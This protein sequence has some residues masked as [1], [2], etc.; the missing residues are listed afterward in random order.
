MHVLPGA[1]GYVA[2]LR[3]CIAVDQV[4][5]DAVKCRRSAQ[6]AIF[7]GRGIGHPNE[8]AADDF[9]GNG[10]GFVPWVGSFDEKGIIV[11]FHGKNWLHGHLTPCFYFKIDP[12]FG[13]PTSVPIQKHVFRIVKT[14]DE[15]TAKSA[16]AACYVVLNNGISIPCQNRD[17][18]RQHAFSISEADINT[19]RTDRET[20]AV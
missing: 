14:P 1:T 7:D 6:P 13:T 18:I 2:D 10:A 16:V 12:A 19:H 17:A 9:E 3:K 11:V 15:R 4:G 5:P 20:S 8:Q